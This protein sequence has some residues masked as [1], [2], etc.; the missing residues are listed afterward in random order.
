MDCA[1]IANVAAS[2]L[3]TLCAAVFVLVYHLKMPWQKT[4]VGRN[5]M[6]FSAAIGALCLYTV[7]I[8]I[9]PDGVAAQ[10]QRFSRTLLLLVIAG[11][12]LQRLHMVLR[13]RHRADE[14]RPPQPTRTTD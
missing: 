4:A 9:W 6:A 13:A 7:T 14:T 3:V 2:A 12:L 10:V 11:L 5:L 8:T 1:Q